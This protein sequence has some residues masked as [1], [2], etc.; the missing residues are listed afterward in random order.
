V[1]SRKRE[2]KRKVL[3][4]VLRKPI[5]PGQESFSSFPWLPP[6]AKK[7][8][9]DEKLEALKCKIEKEGMIFVGRRKKDNWKIL[10]LPDQIEEVQ[11]AGENEPYKLQKLV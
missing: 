5:K 10:I 6:G 7:P 9:T 1:T 8:L 4:I 11:I 3:R 2:E